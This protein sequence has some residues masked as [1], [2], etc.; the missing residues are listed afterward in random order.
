MD[1]SRHATHTVV[2]V[3]QI[4][5]EAARRGI[6]DAELRAL[7][8]MD[9]AE[10]T[11]F[12]RRVP[13]VQVFAAW[14]AVIRRLDE[15][16]FPLR[17]ADAAAHD[18]HSAVF[19]LA[20]SCPKVRDGIVSSVGNARAWTTAYSLASYDTGRGGMTVVLDGLDPGRLGARCE[21]EFQLA[22]FVRGVR[23]VDGAFVPPRVSFAHPAPPDIRAHEEYFGPGVEFGAEHTELEL[24]AEVLDLP[25]PTAHPGLAKVLAGHVAGLCTPGHPE[26]PSHRVRTRRW[27]TA[28]ITAGDAASAACAA[29]AL[30]ISERTLHR[31]LAAEGTTFREQREAVRRELA[32][33]LVRTSRRPIKEIA[34]L[35]GFAD[36]RAFHRAYVRWTGITP[37]QDRG[38]RLVATRVVQS[39]EP[40]CAT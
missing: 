23:V 10:L 15:P 29:R 16:G 20:A 35:T 2:T 7:T 18:A 14:E 32:V 4:W 5:R 19:L 1:R 33:D 25:I 22:D 37:G 26:A 13:A 31:R 38:G 40:S 9:P 34:A 39:P 30:L 21:A 6:G 24:S 8:G 27:L 11:D 12:A 17:V 36:S 28:R 3:H